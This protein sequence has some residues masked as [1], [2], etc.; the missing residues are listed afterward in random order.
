MSR[1]SFALF[2]I[3]AFSCAPAIANSSP[4]VIDGDSPAVAAA[5][6]QAAP[7]EKDGFVFRE[8][9]WES[10][11]SADKGKAVRIQLFKG[12]EYRVCVA[13]EPGSKVKLESHVV[14]ADGKPIESEN[15]SGADGTV[16]NLRV[17][18]EKTGVHLILVRQ[19]GAAEVQ[20]A[21]VIGYR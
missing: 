9:H 5:R 15:V 7:F 2:L 19:D 11:V 1:L 21:L 17:S 12:H 10:P 14:G 20:C 16:V 8:D 6:A 4:D 3:C 13:A 18:P